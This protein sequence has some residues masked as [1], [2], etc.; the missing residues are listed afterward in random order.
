M[1]MF[2]TLHWLNAFFR[3]MHKGYIYRMGDLIH[4]A[5]HAPSPSLVN[6]CKTQISLDTERCKGK[7]P[8]G[9][10]EVVRL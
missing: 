6:R 2:S 9:N 3:A 7:E 8:Q 4:I 1:N 10:A 5:G